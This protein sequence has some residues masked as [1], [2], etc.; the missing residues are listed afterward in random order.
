MCKR[1]GH[2]D[3]M[4]RNRAPSVLCFECLALQSCG[5]DDKHG[6]CKTGLCADVF[7]PFCVPCLALL[8]VS[9][10]KFS[11]AMHPQ[12][13]LDLLQVESQKIEEESEVSLRFKPIS[14]SSD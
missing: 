3:V 4:L 9:A 7:V 1:I 2:G 11:A 6:L 10:E 12:M 13:L 8:L 14:N 5:T